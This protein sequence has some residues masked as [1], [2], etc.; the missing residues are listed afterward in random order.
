MAGLDASR[1]RHRV[2]I[3]QPV[4]VQDTTSGAW[5]T[6]WQTVA[7]DVPAAIEP[8]SVREL[9][10][11]QAEQ[12]RIEARITI[13]YRDGMNGALRIRHPAR[14]RVYSTQGFL[15]DPESGLEWMTAPVTRDI[16]QA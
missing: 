6:T 13:R 1:L 15:P 11:A 3:E 12:T 2:V 5:T 9:M 10:A 16:E 4:R 14:N 8:L 7:S